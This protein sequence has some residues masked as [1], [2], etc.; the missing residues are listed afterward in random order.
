M[1]K[2]IILGSGGAPGVPALAI[3]WGRCN[4]DNPKNYRTRTTVYMV[5]NRTKILI[6]TSPD[7]RAQMLTNNIS[8]FD[9]ILYTHAHADHLNGI[10]DL[11]EVSCVKPEGI[12]F[13]AS[14]ETIEVIK[15]RFPYLLSVPN[16]IDDVVSHPSL[17]AN[18]VKYYEPFFIKDL[19]ITPIRLTGH[20]VP[21]TGYIFNDGEVVYIAD[22]RQMEE[23]AFKHIRKKVKLMIAPLT[24]LNGAAYHAGLK[25]VLNDIERIAPERAVLNHL[26]TKCDYDEISRLTPQNV[27]P[28]FD[29]MKIELD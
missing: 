21:S 23:E 18:E 27:E 1:Y 10:D 6:D 12:N 13:Y 11:R 24:T 29:N 2:I 3:G 25:E 5:Y 7:L 15:K 14:A 19:K 17:V 26:G 9:G 22:Y 28:S 16:R 20:A 8:E 4:P